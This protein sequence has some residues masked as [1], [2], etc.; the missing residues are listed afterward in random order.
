MMRSTLLVFLSFLALYLATAGGHLYSPDEE[1][2]FRVTESLAMRGAL[3][4]EPIVDPAGNSFASRRGQNGLEYAQY[5]IANSLFAVPLY[6]AGAA[7]CELVSSEAAARA[8]SFRTTDYVEPD[9]PK[10]GH[11][12]LKRFAVSF[13]GIIVGA[14]TCAL[15]WRFCAVLAGQRVAWFAAIAYGAG[16]MAWAHSRTFFSEP[17]A[18]FF[19]LLSFYALAQPPRVTILRWALSGAAF[20][21]ALLSRLD[22]AIVFPALCLYA[23]LRHWEG[24][25]GDLRAYF[26]EPASVLLR[27]LFSG[28]FFAALAA[29]AAPL[30][31][32]T[33]FHF[34]LN[35]LHF[36]NPFTSA[37]ADQ[38]EG[39]AFTTPLLAGLYGF[40]LSVGKSIFLFSPALLLALLGWRAL[41]QRHLALSIGCAAATALI[42]LFHARWQNWTG[43]WCWGPRHIF[44]V[45]VFAMLPVVGFVADWTRARKAV[46]AVVMVF[47]AAVQ[48]YGTSQSFIDYYI[49]YFRTPEAPPQAYV[50]FSADDTAPATVRAEQLTKAGTWQPVPP[51]LRITA[52]IND[53]IY[54]PQNSQWYRYAE[55]QG[56]GYTDNLWLRLLK[57]A[58]GE[59]R[60][61]E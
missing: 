61:I 14:A 56:L 41:S 16:T 54:V 39:I 53:S 31:L 48:V 37:Y 26:A 25:H 2:M 27:D 9:A 46:F 24:E 8:L 4:I 6:Y 23:L 18:T 30:A 19:M 42:I 58:V 55:M 36:G 49:L 22:S 17:I 43:G 10:R 29:F 38:A 13:F 57:R 51:G 28:R 20:A 35:A 3:D 47:A 7:A 59:E 33:A 1:I 32:F 34:G 11:L 52:P 50:M 15:F 60:D 12:L 45:H 5:G 40:L 44:Q 21:F